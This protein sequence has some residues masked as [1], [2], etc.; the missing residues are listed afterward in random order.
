MKKIGMKKVGIG[1]AIALL[2]LGLIYLFLIAPRMFGRADLSAFEG[3]T[4]AHRGHHNE[5]VIPENSL[6][7]FVELPHEDFSVA[8]RDKEGV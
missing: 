4:F 1:V 6:A 7:S 5:Q 2:V 3:V 8:E